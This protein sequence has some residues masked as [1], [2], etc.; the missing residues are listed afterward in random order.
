M[1]SNVLIIYQH[2]SRFVNKWCIV[3]LSYS[4]RTVTGVLKTPICVHFMEPPLDAVFFVSG[5]R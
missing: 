5:N 2:I 3:K 1:I 4:K